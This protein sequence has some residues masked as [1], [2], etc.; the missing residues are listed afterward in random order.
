MR[1]LAAALVLAFA[2]GCA[3]F[4]AAEKDPSSAA[5]KAEADAKAIAS[6][7]RKDADAIEGHALVDCAAYAKLGVHVKALDDVCAVVNAIK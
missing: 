1:A 7:V 3:A 5:A 4:K 2:P 6:V